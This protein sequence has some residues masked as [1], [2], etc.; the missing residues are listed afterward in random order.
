MYIVILLYF[1]LVFSFVIMFKLALIGLSLLLLLIYMEFSL[2]L[3]VF[4]FVSELFS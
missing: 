3:L 2:N 4:Y 1:V